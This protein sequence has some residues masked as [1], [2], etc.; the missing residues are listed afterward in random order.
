MLRFEIRL[1]GDEVNVAIIAASGDEVTVLS[2]R[3]FALLIQEAQAIL[4][5]V[6]TLTGE[7]G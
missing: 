2:G 7:E 4:G 1:S 5:R 3:G 6:Q